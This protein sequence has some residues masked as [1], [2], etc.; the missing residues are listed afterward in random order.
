MNTK[1][2]PKRSATLATAPSAS[3]KLPLVKTASSVL[4]LPAHTSL[5]GLTLQRLFKYALLLGIGLG[6]AGLILVNGS[7]RFEVLLNIWLGLVI[8]VIPFLLLGALLAA[9]LATWGQGWLRADR[10]WGRGRLREAV[11][12]VGLGFALPLCEC[13]TASVARQLRRE[14]APLTLALVFLLAA[15][16]V[17]PVTI[18]ATWVAFGGNLLFVVGRIGLAL[19]VALSL[20]FFLSLYP[21]PQELFSSGPGSEPSHPDHHAHAG[22][23]HTEGEDWSIPAAPFG[24]KWTKF[25]DRAGLEFLQT[26]RIALPGLALAAS[27]QT[28]FP[29]RSLLDLGQG[30][31]LSAIALMVLGSLMSV[32]SSVDAFIA[33]TFV[34][35]FPA[36]SV[37]AFLVFSPLINLKTVFLLQLVLR[38]RTIGLVAF[39]SFQIVLLAAVLINL[40]LG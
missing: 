16:V 37:L 34:S 18:L 25:T 8:E 23:S 26:T 36:G 13:G 3:T 14:G 7:A 40:R 24:G 33:L 17:N 32:C 30:A 12:G 29:T 11:A 5:A 31:L 15:P 1:S 39:F 10:L 6:W 9:A 28:Y 20:G 2:E 38:R 4:V 21:R 27:V 35:L 22:H 19:L